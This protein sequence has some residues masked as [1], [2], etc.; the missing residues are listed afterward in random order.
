MISQLSSWYRQFNYISLL[1]HHYPP[2]YGDWISI[3]DYYVWV[4]I[5]NSNFWGLKSQ[6]FQI[7][8]DFNLAYG[9]FVQ[10]SLCKR[11]KKVFEVF[12]DSS[13]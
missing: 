10:L 3:M 12:Q 4:S 8:S 11:E 13:E 5:T 6:S 9:L 1:Q 7:A 2:D